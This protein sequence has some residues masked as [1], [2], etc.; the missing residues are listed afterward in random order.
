MMKINCT[1]RAGSESAQ[2]A[3]LLMKQD[4][5]VR[6]GPLEW[7]RYTIADKETLGLKLLGSV[8]R[9]AGVGALALL[10]DGSLCKSTGTS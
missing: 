9:G 6:L 10:A 7:S 5:T 8:R 3:R 1:M 4:W 2:P